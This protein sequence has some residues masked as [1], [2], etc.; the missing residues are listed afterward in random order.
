MINRITRLHFSNGNKYHAQ[1]TF[2][3]LCNRWFASKAECLRAT[4]LYLLQQGD[5]ISNLE[6]QKRFV[7][8]KKPLVT[9][10]IDFQYTE[11]GKTV[12]EDTKGV[13]TRDFRT[14][15]AWL[16]QLYG[17]DVKLTHNRL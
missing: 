13:L 7:L 9:I 3:P 2:S 11:K 4:E 10:T 14:K 6:Y 1:R 12:L 17:L 8:S 16:K 15:L 5:M